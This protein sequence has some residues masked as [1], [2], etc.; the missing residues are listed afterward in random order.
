MV[1][2]IYVACHKPVFVPKHPLLVPIQVGAALSE[3]DLT[4]WFM[5]IPA[6]TFLC[7][8]KVIVN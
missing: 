8:I 7:L 6:I 5:M 4:A 2:K 3:K 1:V